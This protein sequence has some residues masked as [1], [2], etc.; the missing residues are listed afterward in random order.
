M[1]LVSSIAALDLI[2]RRIFFGQLLQGWASLIV[3][4][5]LLGGLTLFCLGV[6]GVYLSKIFIETKQRPYTIIREIYERRSPSPAPHGSEIYSRR[7]ERSAPGKDDYQ[8][9]AE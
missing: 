5:W 8:V 7:T 3:S 6:V 1:S 2:I 4:I 9:S